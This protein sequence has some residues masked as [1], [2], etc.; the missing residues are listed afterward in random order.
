MNTSNTLTISLAIQ[1]G[2][3]GKTTTAINLGAA[4]M[5]MGFKVLLID[6]DPQS[7]LTQALGI[8]EKP[9]PNL[10]T[11]LKNESEGEEA[12]LKSAIMPTICGLNLIPATLDLAS[13]ELEL[14]NKF[15]RE[16]LF[17]D[18]LEDVKKD[19]DF[20]FI[21]CPPSIGMLTAN[22]LV[23]SDHIL[24]PLQAEFL[25]LKGV[26]SFMRAMQPL[27]KKLNPKLEI[28]GF[29]LTKYDRRKTMNRQVL[30][31]LLNEFGEKVFQT[32]IRTN[33]ALAQAQEN[34]VDIFT[35]D[36]RS[37]GAIDYEALAR[38]FLNKIKVDIPDSK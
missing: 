18:L 35:Y 17:N 22:A 24:M 26:K 19:Y 25:P 20:I 36:K 23:T 5:R 9:E 13:A 14:V 7:N 4:L 21:D 1:K 10:Y 30:Q 32:H 12:D 29:V 34:G 28:L 3:S 33:I 37:N 15:A 8:L 2:G 16:Q 38:E 27:Q 11:V 6:M 31:D